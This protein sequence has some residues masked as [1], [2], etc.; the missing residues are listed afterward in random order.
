MLDHI[1]LNGLTPQA[2]KRYVVDNI[3]ALKQ[4]Q[5]ERRK[6]ADELKKWRDRVVL[7]REKGRDDLAQKASE[8][9]AETEAKLRT[10]ASEERQLELDVI[11]LKQ[12]LANL[13][14]QPSRT[15]DAEA[16]LAQLQNVVGERDELEEAMKDAELDVE[17]EKL[18]DRTSDDS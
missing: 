11:D 15:I 5:N 4:T 3:A 12:K 13:E 14:K 17:L 7:A 8:V 6:L 16:L 18:K 1:D 10:I 9:V 2:A